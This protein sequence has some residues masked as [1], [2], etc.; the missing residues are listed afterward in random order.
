MMHSMQNVLLLFV[1]RLHEI[2][3]G[4]KNVYSMFL[5]YN[6]DP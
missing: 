6:F 3:K 5:P 1:T 2:D 4:S